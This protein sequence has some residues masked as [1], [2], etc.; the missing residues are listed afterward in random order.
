MRRAAIDQL[1]FNLRATGLRG[2]RSWQNLWHALPRF[3]IVA[4][5]DILEANW[6]DIAGSS[7]T[8]LWTGGQAARN[9]R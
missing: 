2:R 3:D 1:S 9:G 7:V 4:D 6:P 5:R 8:Q